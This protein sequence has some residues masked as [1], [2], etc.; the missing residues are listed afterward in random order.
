MK[1]GVIATASRGTDEEEE[2]G[3]MT[4]SKCECEGRTRLGMK[5]RREVISGQKAE[6]ITVCKKAVIALG[7]QIVT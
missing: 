2:V 4:R 3:I 1:K 7:L 6:R 5:V